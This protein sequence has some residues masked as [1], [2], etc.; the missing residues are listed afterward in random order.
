MKAIVHTGY[1]PPDELQLMEV[2]KPVPKENE[3]RIKIHAS[4]VT[5]TDCN[6]R[7]ATF[8]PK[9]MRLPVLL[10]FGYPEPNT[11][12]LGTDL[13]G[14]IEAVGNDVTRFAVG[15]QVFGTP[16]PAFGAH[17][18]YVCMPENG[19]LAKMPTSLTYEEAA[20]I[21]LA[22]HTAM[23]F[24]KDQGNV[25]AGQRVLI[26]GASGA[27]GT[28]AVQLAKHYGAEVTGVCSTRNLELVESLGA[29][30]VIDYKKEDFT[31]GGETYDV[32][33][34]AVS[35]SSFWR[36]RGSLK[37][38]GLYLATLPNLAVL[39]ATLWTSKVGDKKA[40]NGSREATLEDI[41]FLGELA[42]AGKLRTVIDRRYPL[43]ET[44]EA[45]RYV[46]K[47]HKR[48][49]VVINVIPTDMA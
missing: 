4:T 24:I 14:E 10:G 46:E 26:N 20:C 48:G 12:I 11:K 22:G 30:Q 13:A 15:D 16:E 33:F 19:V 1:G 31:R 37:K 7:N 38:N 18:D 8:V 35:K 9:F 47:G 28:T 41:V 45:F 6:L 23:Y 39:L 49:N 34:D 5:T 40:K 36:C 3:V 29:D 25:Q 21:P 32:I 43:E 2:D 17:A 44:A 27:V 42:E